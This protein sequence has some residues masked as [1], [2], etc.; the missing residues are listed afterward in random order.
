[1]MH[2]TIVELVAT[3]ERL[4]RDFGDAIVDRNNPNGQIK[5]ARYRV[6]L[7]ACETKLGRWLAEN[8]ETTLFH[9]DGSRLTLGFGA[10]GAG[11]ALR[12][13]GGRLQRASEVGSRA[14]L[15]A[16]LAYVEN[17]IDELR[18]MADAHSETLFAPSTAQYQW[19][20]FG[21][22]CAS[23]AET[24]AQ[25]FDTCA[26]D[27]RRMGAVILAAGLKGARPPDSL[28]ATLANNGGL[29]L[30]ERFDRLRRARGEAVS[31]DGEPVSDPA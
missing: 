10:T 31:D 12:D 7:E 5:A 2:E 23:S 13:L 26:R 18:R 15:D 25:F 20:V 6:D 22:H 14:C 28:Q 9:D 16:E 24:P 21:S 8:I 30:V 19:P 1:M 3:E 11:Q 27:I 17:Q 4:R 29:Y